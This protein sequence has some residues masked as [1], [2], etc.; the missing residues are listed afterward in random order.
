MVTRAVLLLTLTLGACASWSDYA[1]TCEGSDV[2]S[3]DDW[4]TTDECLHGA[5]I[6]VDEGA[7]QTPEAYAAELCCT[8]EA[9]DCACTCRER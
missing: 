8:P 5:D 7:D 3:Q 9:A 6:S 1:C 2:A 4:W